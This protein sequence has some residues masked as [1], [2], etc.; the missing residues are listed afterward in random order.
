[1]GRAK[2]ILHWNFV[3]HLVGKLEG[4]PGLI[5]RRI[6]YSDFPSFLGHVFSLDVSLDGSVVIGGSEKDVIAHNTTTGAVLWRK[7][8]PG[9]VWTLRIHGSVVVVPVD[10]SDTVVLDAT[11]GRYLHALPSAGKRVRGIC[12]FDGL[13]SA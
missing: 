2:H 10:N 4:Y 3:T 7:E 5:S 13:V 11:T 6:L 1:M 8:M 12:V 9:S